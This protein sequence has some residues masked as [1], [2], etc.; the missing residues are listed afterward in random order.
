[1][2]RKP[3]A[4]FQSKVVRYLKDAYGPRLWLANQLGGLGARAGIPD[5]LV[6]IDGRFVALELKTPAGTGRLGPKQAQ[7][8]K[9]IQEAGGV[10]LVVSTWQ[11]LKAILNAF[12]PTQ[13]SIDPQD[14]GGPRDGR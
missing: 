11:D 7:E 8:I 13:R 6:C 4:A 14:Q 9:A 1:M 2:N 3:E 12:P 5:L 10:A